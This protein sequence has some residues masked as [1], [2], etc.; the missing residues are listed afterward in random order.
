[1]A[2]DANEMPSHEIYFSPPSLEGGSRM[3]GYVGE[4]KFVHSGFSPSPN[5]LH[6]FVSTSPTPTGSSRLAEVPTPTTTPESTHGSENLFRTREPRFKSP[7]LPASARHPSFHSSNRTSSRRNSL[8]S[9]QVYPETDTPESIP[10]SPPVQYSPS[11]SS[12]PN[13]SSLYSCWL[14]PP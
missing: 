4:S 10:P 5:V 9:N 3:S 12:H 6:S 13:A 1:M 2:A 11:H 7:G 8:L 14:P